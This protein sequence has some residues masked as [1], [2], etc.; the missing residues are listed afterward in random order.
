[1]STQKVFAT[2]MLSLFFMTACKKPIEEVKYSLKIN[3]ETLLFKSKGGSQNIEI[4]SSPETW[5]TV[6]K[7]P[8]WIMVEKMDTQTAK[9]SVA[10]NHSDQE[11]RGSVI[12]AC[13]E[14]RKVVKI[15]QSP[16]Y[17]F[18]IA[19]HQIDFDDVNIPITVK[20]STNTKAHRVVKTPKWISPKLLDTELVLTAEDNNKEEERKGEIL[21]EAQGIQTPIIIKVSQAPKAYVRL[22][23]EPKIFSYLGGEQTVI[24]NTNR[25]IEIEAH[26]YNPDS[27]FKFDLMDENKLHI[28][29]PRNH[30]TRKLWQTF[31]FVY[32]GRTLLA[33]NITQEKSN[34]AEDQKA[35]LIKFYHST[36]G[37]GWKNNTNW[38]S[39]KPIS[40]WYGI[41]VREGDD[42]NA[43]IFR[44]D[45]S[46]NNLKG[47]IPEGF[48]IL[49]GARFIDL[50]NNALEGSIP[51]DVCDINEAIF[52]HL[53]N[54]NLTGNIPVNICKIA[55][56]GGFDFRWNKLTG[57]LPECFK[58]N[59]SNKACP[60]KKGYQFDNYNCEDNL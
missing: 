25:N 2:F 24:F 38:L 37:K 10:A 29:C 4:K 53:Q 18:K 51:E 26:P 30:I 17:Y 42:P 48:S 40:E 60:Q 8:T 52:L 1:M 39:D 23:E 47:T 58:K 49:V 59:L 55:A 16:S 57:M 31:H 43:G 28:T 45:L 5:S 34:L 3:P 41:S 22:V 19:R 21:L 54:N 56:I 27:S 15:E 6:N 50:Q 44:I 20:Y 13:G 35:Y 11:R 14:L 9:I 12:F 7:H 32:K 33:V 46:N 36:G